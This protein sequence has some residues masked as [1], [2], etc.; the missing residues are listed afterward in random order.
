MSHEK[1]IHDGKKESSAF[2]KLKERRAEMKAKRK[3]RKAKRAETK[4]HRKPRHKPV[5]S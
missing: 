1:T 2:K 4:H 5:T 3:E